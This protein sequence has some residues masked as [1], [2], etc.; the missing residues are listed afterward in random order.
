MKNS[1]CTVFVSLAAIDSFR[2]SVIKLD[3]Y[4]EKVMIPAEKLFI[5]LS[6]SGA[7]NTIIT[8]NDSEKSS[9]GTYY[10]ATVYVFASDFMARYITIPNSY[11]SGDQAMALRISED[12]FVFY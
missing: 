12:R 11:G 2:A 10:C 8:W 3:I 5:I 4:E 6:G 7:N 9:G 1:L